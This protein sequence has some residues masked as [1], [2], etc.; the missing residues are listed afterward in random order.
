M[1]NAATARATS[2]QRMQ[3]RVNRH[4]IFT[5][6]NIFI[7]VFVVAI[8]T[9]S[10]TITTIIIITVTFIILPLQNEIQR[11]QA[12]LKNKLH[13]DKKESDDRQQQQQD[14]HETKSPPPMSQFMR[15]QV[16]LPSF[17]MFYLLPSAPYRLLLVIAAWITN[18]STVHFPSSPLLRRQSLA[19]LRGRRCRIDRQL[20]QSFGQ[21]IHR[22]RAQD[23]RGAFFAI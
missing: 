3:V 7:I 11:V 6:G 14:A 13:V 8:T 17:A 16:P 22:F 1:Q 9:T 10:T 18:S 4:V 12:T 21:S 2:M 20:F 5:V 19:R 23:K 15:S